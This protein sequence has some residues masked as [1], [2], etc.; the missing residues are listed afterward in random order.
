LAW[1]AFFPTT[2]FLGITVVTITA[3]L[4]SLNPGMYLV[5][6]GK[7]ISEMEESAF[8][9]INLLMLPAIPLII[10][11]VGESNINLVTPLLA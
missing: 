2:G 3:V 8:S 4:M 11:S 7:D 10:L 5:L 9:V 6:L 1:K